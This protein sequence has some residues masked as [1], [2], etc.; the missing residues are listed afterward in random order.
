MEKWITHCDGSEHAL[1]ANADDLLVDI[2]TC[3]ID[4][5]E[6]LKQ[7]NG[8]QAL[9]KS[10]L[11]AVN[12][13]FPLPSLTQTCLS[14]VARRPQHPLPCGHWICSTCVLVFGKAVETDYFLFTLDSCVV[15]GKDTNKRRIRIVPFTASVR[16]M[17]V[18]GGG[19]KGRGPL[20]MLKELQRRVNLP[21][22][23]QRNFDFIF[24]TSSGM[25][26]CKW[27]AMS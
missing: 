24:G 4:K 11:A 5:F 20:E 23:V 8:S 19:A 13:I 10:Q 6:Q 2:H 14:C 12:A 7:F 15:C 1:Q 17:C 9:Q 27:W 25:L 26:R 22:L 18:E 16:S 3:L 21:Y